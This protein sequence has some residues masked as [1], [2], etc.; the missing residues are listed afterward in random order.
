MPQKHSIAYFSL[1]LYLDIQTG[2]FFS[3]ILILFVF[4]LVQG[5]PPLQLA[6]FLQF[7]PHYQLILCNILFNIFLLRVEP[8]SAFFVLTVLP[9]PLIVGALGA[10]FYIFNIFCKLLVFLHN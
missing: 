1:H 8:E 9:V 5:F 6:C 4:L 10:F 3:F 2:Y 7:R